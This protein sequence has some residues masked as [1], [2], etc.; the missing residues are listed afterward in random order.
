VKGIILEALG[1]HPAPRYGENVLEG[2]I[3]NVK[4][5]AIQTR[6]TK[7]AQGVKELSDG[8]ISC[9]RLVLPGTES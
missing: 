1:I 2:K 6:E 8:G 4:S 9:D 3:G 7:T 5:R